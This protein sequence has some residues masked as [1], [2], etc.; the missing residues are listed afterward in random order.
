MTIKILVVDDEP[1][2]CDLMR[3]FLEGKGYSVVEAFDGDQALELY[4]RERPDVVLLDMRMPGKSG[5][6]T[7]RELRAFDPEARVIMVTAIQQEELDQQA[8]VEVEEGVLDYITKPFD[9][10]S[11][12]R[13]LAIL[14]RIKLLADGD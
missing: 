11:L 12:E 8:V 4:K 10:D 9:H 13:T 6:E 1:L 2:H 14:M 5:L 7:L 3:E